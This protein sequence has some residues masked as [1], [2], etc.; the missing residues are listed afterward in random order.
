MMQRRDQ[1]GGPTVQRKGATEFDAW[2][3]HR[4]THNATANWHFIIAD[5][6]VKVKSL[7]PVIWEMQ[8]DWKHAMPL[9]PEA[10]LPLFRTA[11]AERF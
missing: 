7:D 2:C 1:P 11:R 6:R 8:V 5:A 10:F 9:V 3:T 4:K